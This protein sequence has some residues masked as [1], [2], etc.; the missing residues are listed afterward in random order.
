MY[1]NCLLIQLQR[2]RNEIL[3]EDILTFIKETNIHLDIVQKPQI[4]NRRHVIQ[5]T[6][7]LQENGPTIVYTNATTLV[8]EGIPVCQNFFRPIRN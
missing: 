2:S 7:R 8:Y 3:K 4:L 6:T 1:A 5:L